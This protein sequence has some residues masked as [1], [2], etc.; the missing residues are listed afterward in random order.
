MQYWN[1]TANKVFLTV[2]FE[3]LFIGYTH[4]QENSPY[5]RYGLGNLKL[6]ENVVNRGMGGVSIADDNNLT[7]NPTNP[8][9]FANLRMTAYQVGIE[10]S[11]IN[12]RNSDASNRTGSMSLSY[13]NLGF[14]LS[15]H[16][17]V[18]FGLMPQTRSK[19]QMEQSDSLD[20]ISK[21]TNHYYGGG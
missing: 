3:L 5:S 14:P 18:S 19:F 20:G 8:A 15:K 10:G 12:V 11:S 7:V 13:V 1:T 6:T 4:A 17:G 16:V 21:V 9:S 2:L